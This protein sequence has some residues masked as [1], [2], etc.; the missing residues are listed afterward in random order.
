MGEHGGSLAINID[1]TSFLKL[2]DGVCT[3]EWALEARAIC[4]KDIVQRLIGEATYE[5]RYSLVSF[6]TALVILLTDVE[7]V[8]FRPEGLPCGCHLS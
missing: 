3:T 6:K 8:E 2:P 5:G 7:I 4:K 1:P